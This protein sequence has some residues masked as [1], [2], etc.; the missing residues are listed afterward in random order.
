MTVTHIAF[1]DEPGKK[2]QK[3]SARV[4]RA[5]DEL[6]EYWGKEAWSVRVGENVI[7]DRKLTWDDATAIR[8]A[9]DCAEHVLSIFENWAQGKDSRPRNAIATARKYADSLARKLEGGA[10]W[11]AEAAEGK[12]QRQKLMEYLLSEL[13]EEPVVTLP[14][15]WIEI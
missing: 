9:A 15:S 11:A 2:G 5:P 12:W 3:T 13:S 6:M 1:L 7:L 14:E 8:W 4:L 10:A